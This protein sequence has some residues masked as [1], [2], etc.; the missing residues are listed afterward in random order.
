VP[1]SHSGHFLD[2]GASYLEKS[3]SPT[4]NTSTSTAYSAESQ[5]RSLFVRKGFGHRYS[6]GAIFRSRAKLL[7]SQARQVA[8]LRTDWLGRKLSIMD[9]ILDSRSPTVDLDED[10][11]LEAIRRTQEPTCP[12]R[13]QYDFTDELSLETYWADEATRWG[14]RTLE[15]VTTRFPDSDERS[16]ASWSPCLDGKRSAGFAH[17]DDIQQ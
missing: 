3:G 4:S 11:L 7:I 15:T 14:M 6:S 17:V 16:T 1:L 9:V 2:S 10:A 8:L 13:C 12:L 5:F